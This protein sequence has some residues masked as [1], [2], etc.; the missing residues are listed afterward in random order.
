M[1]VKRVARQPQG[2]GERQTLGT[3]G[4]YEGWIL[5]RALG[6]AGN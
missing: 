5:A 6:A 3:M 2:G 4:G 1:G